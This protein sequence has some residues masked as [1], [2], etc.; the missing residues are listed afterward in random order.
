METFPTQP[1]HS[2]NFQL[3]CVYAYAQTHTHTS[4]RLHSCDLYSSLLPH[5]ICATFVAS[6]SQLRLTSCSR[7][8]RIQAVERV[9]YH[10]SYQKLVCHA[11][12]E[13]SEHAFSA[14][15]NFVV[16]VLVRSVSDDGLL[17]ARFFIQKTKNVGKQS[18]K[19]NKTQVYRSIS[20]RHW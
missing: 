9:L 10:G 6:S 18:W 13:Y 1:A 14:D 11:K 12:S 17:F 15:Q 16:C 5:F 8:N 19:T 20:G 4:A 7:G 3:K 2:E